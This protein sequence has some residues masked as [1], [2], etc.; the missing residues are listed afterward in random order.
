[1]VAIAR[2]FIC[3]YFIIYVNYKAAIKNSEVCTVQIKK[4]GFK[5]QVFMYC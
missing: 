2:I 5:I 3:P 1:M 4:L